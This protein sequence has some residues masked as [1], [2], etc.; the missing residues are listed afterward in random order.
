MLIDR[1]AALNNNYSENYFNNEAYCIECG[2][3]YNY[4]DV[5]VTVEINGEDPIDVY[6]PAGTAY[7]DAF[8]VIKSET[9]VSDDANYGV[10]CSNPECNGWFDA[11]R[12][13][14]FTSGST[15]TVTSLIDKIG[16]ENVIKRFYGMYEDKALLE[17]GEH[18]D[19]PGRKFIVKTISY[20]EVT[21]SYVCESAFGIVRDNENAARSMQI[22]YRINS[23]VTLRNLLLYGVENIHYTKDDNGVVTKNPTS[24]YKMRLEYTGNIFLAYPCSD[25]IW[26]GEA[27]TNESKIN[28]QLQNAESVATN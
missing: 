6:I 18:P 27:W 14:N 7:D 22:V 17:N 12:A 24:T 2:T 1:E 26:N 11:Y 23:D 4:G 16:E 19:Y 8:D 21:K 10:R 5:T 28:G 25:P 3:F 15:S 9:K 20:P 13:L